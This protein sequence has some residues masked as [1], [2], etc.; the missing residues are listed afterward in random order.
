MGTAF[1]GE[2][3]KESHANQN[4]DAEPECESGGVEVEQKGGRA[5]VPLD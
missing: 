5:G 1:P 2:E 3:A 4:G